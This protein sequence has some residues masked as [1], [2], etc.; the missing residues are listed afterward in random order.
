MKHKHRVNRESRNQLRQY[1]LVSM[2][3]M[4]AW[5][6]RRRKHEG[7]LRLLLVSWDRPRSL[8]VTWIFILILLYWHWGIN[9]YAG[10]ITVIEPHKYLCLHPEHPSRQLFWYLRYISIIY[11]VGIV[12]ERDALWLVHRCNT[13]IFHLGRLLWGRRQLNCRNEIDPHSITTSMFSCP[14]CLRLCCC[15]FSV[16]SHAKTYLFVPPSQIWRWR[17]VRVRRDR[18]DCPDMVYIHTGSLRSRIF[19]D[20]WFGLLFQNNI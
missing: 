15:Y 5:S 10:I 13:R 11:S 17:A 20:V 3:S 14:S 16:V 9:E 12:W 2:C 18:L 19:S 4:R 6:G 8:G 7:S 1:R